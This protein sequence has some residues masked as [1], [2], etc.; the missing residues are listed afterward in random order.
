MTVHKSW[1]VVKAPLTAE[2]RE[3][4]GDPANRAL[5]RGKV[6]EWMRGRSIPPEARDR[7]LADADL[8]LVELAQLY[9]PAKSN[10]MSFR[11]YLHSMT[12][13]RVQEI[14][15]RETEVG[16][17]GRRGRGLRGGLKVKE[18]L[19]AETGAGT[20]ADSLPDPHPHSGA[21]EFE[22]REYVERHLVG[23][24]VRQR[25]VARA[26]LLD[27]SIA[28]SAQLAEEMGCGET[29]IS[30]LFKQFVERVRERE[31]VECGTVTGP[32]LSRHRRR[33]VSPASTAGP[34][35]SG[36]TAK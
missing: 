22:Y 3:L 19:D 31:G 5:A 10:G 20:L 24:P 35:T 1:H 30:N 28:T 32:R 27:A 36:P 2:Q 23:C 12:V 21:E 29:Y 9:D 15:R 17:F 6:Q 25:V 14:Q 13:R 18:S 11:G 26:I 4:A 33:S 16:R 8:A 7:I 34:G